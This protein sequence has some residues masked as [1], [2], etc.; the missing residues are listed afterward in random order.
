M[1]ADLDL[2]QGAEVLLT[3][4]VL[5]L[6]D[7]ALDAVI[8]AFLMLHGVSLL[9]FDGMDSMPASPCGYSPPDREN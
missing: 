3:A 1:R 6:R 9:N 4:V 5:T 2:V 7:R 8:C